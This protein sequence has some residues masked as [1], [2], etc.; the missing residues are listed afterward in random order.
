MIV[1]FFLNI[2]LVI[3]NFIVNLLPTTPFP[4]Q[5]PEGIIAFW[6][7]V[8]LFSLVIPVSTLLTVIV[9]SLFYEGAILVW[10]AFHWLLRRIPFMH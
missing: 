7:Y 4:P 8:N 10:H 2:G 5:I 3:V 1:G 6:G 9:F